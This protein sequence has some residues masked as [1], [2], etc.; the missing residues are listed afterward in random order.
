MRLVDWLL[1]RAPRERML[2]GLLVLVILPAALVFGWLLPLE[3]RRGATETG[4]AEA[5]ALNVW[6]RDRQGEMAGL[7]RVDPVEVHEAVGASA[8][9]QSLE[10]VRL[11]G[12]LTALETDGDGGVVLRFDAVG[13]GELMAWI[14]GQA[15]GWGYDITAFR[16]ERGE[17]EGFISA[18]L[19][20]AAVE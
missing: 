11:R 5:Q 8:L 7:A 3:A 14:D 12:A 15:P 9:E 2:L 13:F 18:R 1:G 20:L 10:A 16:M 17:R 4:L 19:V 6:V